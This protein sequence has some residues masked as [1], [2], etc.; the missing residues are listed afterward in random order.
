MAELRQRL[1][2]FGDDFHSH[3]LSERNDRADDFDVL[4][5]FTDASDERA[6]NFQSID[7]EAMQI[8]ERGIA[9][10][11]IVYA[12][13]HSQRFQAPQELHGCLG[14]VHDGAFRDL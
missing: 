3:V 13:L 9:G 12:Q 2:T 7:R 8:T 6:V 14:I 10:A 11:E 1:D 5:S 4:G